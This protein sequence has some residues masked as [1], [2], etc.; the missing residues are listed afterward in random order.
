MDKTTH[1]TARGSG[2]SLFRV[3]N[4]MTVV[5]VAVGVSTVICSAGHPP[6]LGAAIKA[7]QSL[8][9]KGTVV[10]GTVGGTWGP[11]RR[12]FGQMVGRAGLDLLTSDGRYLTIARCIEEPE[13]QGVLWPANW[14]RTE[15][16][17]SEM[18]PEVRGFASVRVRV[19]DRL[20]NERTSEPYPLSGGPGTAAMVPDDARWLALP[21][22]VTGAHGAPIVADETTLES[23]RR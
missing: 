10:Y 21:A 15:V 13:W 14:W 19:T 12:G 22:I 2:K 1:L 5:F 16:W 23:P 9:G 3:L 8:P 20:G 7:V 18:L 6:T 17:F 4:R 11:L